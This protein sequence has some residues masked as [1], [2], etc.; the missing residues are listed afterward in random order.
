M[1]TFIQITYCVQTNEQ[2][3]VESG[4][5]ATNINHDRS[6]GGEYRSRA[7]GVVKK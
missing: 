7:F 3:K 6:Y 1:V 4:E 2:L 5:R